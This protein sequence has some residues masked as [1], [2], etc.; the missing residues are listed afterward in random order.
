VEKQSACAAEIKKLE[1]QLAVQT[2]LPQLK[3]DIDRM[4]DKI[5]QNERMLAQA[6]E[7]LVTLREK[8]LL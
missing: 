8:A 1:G 3:G 2:S 4:N 6:Q 7:Q 5:R